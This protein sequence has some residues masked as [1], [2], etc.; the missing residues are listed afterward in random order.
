MRV[1]LGWL[2]EWIDLPGSVEDLEERLTMG[3]LEIEEILR[4]GPDL[5][6]LRVG[7][8]I[9]HAR[10]PDAD[11]LSVCKVDLGDGEPLEMVCGAHNVAAG[12]KV[13]VAT[14]G[15][16]LPGGERVKRARIRGVRSNGMIC[17]D[18][19]M[20]LGDDHQGIRVLDP[21]APVGAPLSEV[22]RCGETVFEV[23][24][25]PNRGDW[26]SMLGMAREVRAHFGGEIR[27]PPTE[28][29]EGERPA[30]QD[31]RVEIDDRG[32][33]HRY[34]ARVVRGVEMGASPEWLR[35][36]LEAAGQRSIN[37][38]VD[39]TNLVLLEFGQPL[40]A[41]DLA[42]LR[43]GV[44][45]VRAAEQGEKIVTLDGQTRELCPEDLVIADAEGA[46]AIAGVMGGFE[47]EVGEHT[48]AVL[49]ESAH[50]QPS[51]VRRT[52]RRLGLQTDASY[53]FERGVDR[54]GC[55]R[56]AARTA[57]LIQELGGGTIS[58]G[59]VEVLGEPPQVTEQ[60]RLDPSRAN[61][62][63]G[64][65]IS[66]EEMIELLSRLDIEATRADEGSLACRPPSYR[67]DLHLPADLIEEIARLH[68][69]DRIPST[70]PEGAFA[71]VEVPPHRRLMLEVSQSL[72]GSGLTE[73]MTFPA[74]RPGDPDALQL[75]PEDPRRRAVELLNPIQ[76]TDSVLRTTLVPS[77]LRATQTNLRRQVERLRLFELSRVFLARGADELP[78][79]PL[80]AVAVLSDAEGAS[81]WESQEVPIFFRAKGV[82]ERLL[83]DLGHTWAFRA[84]TSEPYLH[85]G[86]AGE[87]CIGEG[88]VAVAGELHPETAAR[89]EIEAP[90][91][92]LVVDLEALGRVP[93]RDPQYR[94]ISY[95]PTVRRDLA[96]LLDRATQAG[97]LL[98]AIRKTGGA[99]LTSVDVFDRWE[100]RGV[101]EG[102]V[103][104]TFRLVFQRVDRSLTDPEVVKATDRVVNLLAHRFGGELR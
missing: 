37:P 52:A 23:S 59:A 32:G 18:R 19:E 34:V 55:G 12:Q 24:I 69:Y 63:L 38:V 49:I 80:Q 61:R 70:L 64:T 90:T 27:T 5:S 67:N 97:E 8:V 2:S 56:A 41:F 92:M 40:H 84:G 20:H 42:K 11:R 88:R 76:S 46:I 39:V 51:R 89:F 44:V 87:F 17:S 31:I 104:L 62:L 33:C 68:G 25:T 77:L 7:H 29:P 102:K 74:A 43:G 3:G 13:A 58:N 94:E 60:I 99:A 48:T 28:V 16:V 54:E 21:D 78:E 26:V 53:R 81:L 1:P 9:E 50:F 57:R 6:G 66:D 100:G 85:P 47:S 22:V 91:A 65:A 35:E 73:V 36:R 82:G 98:E 14:H 45:R 15:T 30:S 101:P 95:H 83:A 4:T 96:V 79:E 10:H 86:A 71:G 75:A 93:R 72:Q 103:S